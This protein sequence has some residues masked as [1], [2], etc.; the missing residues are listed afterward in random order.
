LKGK[1]AKKRK[2]RRKI[3]RGLRATN[4]RRK[5]SCLMLIAMLQ[6]V[7]LLNRV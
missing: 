5:M 3:P 1:R 2:S 7:S 6:R 4:K